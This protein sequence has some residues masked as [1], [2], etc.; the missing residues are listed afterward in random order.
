MVSR[1]ADILTVQTVLCQA[2]LARLRCS[3]DRNCRSISAEFDAPFPSPP[4][5][6]LYGAHVSPSSISV[7]L[8]VMHT[9]LILF[10]LNG[11][12]YVSPQPCVC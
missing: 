5:A 8:S 4:S 1:A 9:A 10:L 11:V 3:Q 6:E 2:H 7:R 12:R